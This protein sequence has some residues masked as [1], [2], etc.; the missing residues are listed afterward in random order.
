MK[1]CRR[2]LIVLPA[3]QQRRLSL[4]VMSQP[5]AKAATLPQTAP[6]RHQGHDD[7][8]FRATRS[9][10]PEIVIGRLGFA[11]AQRLCRHQPPPDFLA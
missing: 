1:Y 6:F 9:W 10:P 7:R 3:S 5:A 4:S 11:T 8:P 2:P